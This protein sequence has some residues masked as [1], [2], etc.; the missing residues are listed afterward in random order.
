[1][2]AARAGIATSGLSI[3]TCLGGGLQ[4]R[5]PELGWLNVPEFAMGQQAVDMVEHAIAAP[6]VPRPS[7]VVPYTD[8]HLHG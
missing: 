7:V 3:I 8:I 2:L 4:P 5:W 1:M 6:G